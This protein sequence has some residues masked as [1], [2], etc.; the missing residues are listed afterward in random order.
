MHQTA[1][2]GLYRGFAWEQRAG[3][4][5]INFTSAAARLGVRKYGGRGGNV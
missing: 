5:R 4:R 2:P 3:K 1:G